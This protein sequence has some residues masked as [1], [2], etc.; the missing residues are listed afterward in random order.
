MIN[1]DRIEVA[2]R[3]YHPRDLRHEFS[4]WAARALGA[5]LE[6][7][8]SGLLVPDSHSFMHSGI[9]AVKMA[10]VEIASQ[11]E[12]DA[13]RFFLRAEGL[14]VIRFAPVG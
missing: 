8:P 6:A 9:A 13:C 14:K 3:V 10:G 11:R 1:A 5:L 7:G 12:D 4:G 2:W